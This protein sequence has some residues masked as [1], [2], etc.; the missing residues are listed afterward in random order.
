M[1]IFLGAYWKYHA[2]SL[3]EYIDKLRIFLA[4]VQAAH[5]AF[6]EL[7]NVGSESSDKII[8]LDTGLDNL[9][10]LAKKR[11]F[12][13]SAS[14]K[15]Y[16]HW[17]ADGTPSLNAISDLGYNLSFFNNKKTGC[18]EADVSVR[19]G[20]ASEHLNNAIVVKFYDDFYPEARNT[21]FWIKLMQIT[22]RYW[23]PDYIRVT[24]YQFVDVTETKTDDFEICWLTYFS[25]PR[26]LQV[27]DPRIVLHPMETGAWFQISS[28]PA[29]ADN[30]ADVA[31]AIHIRDLLRPMGLLQYRKPQ[32]VV[33]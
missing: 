21:D 6:H 5:E 1:T 32:L 20:A 22:A 23:N 28:A 29:S 14:K 25:D 19:T 7:Y 26:I 24:N 2:L 11:A 16:S 10:N 30:P 27:K 8:K 13:R 15:E 12:N 9:P 31:K 33:A 4:D 18:G 17:D 3:G